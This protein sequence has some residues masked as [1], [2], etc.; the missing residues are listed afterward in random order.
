METT[1]NP[2]RHRALQRYEDRTPT[3]RALHEKACR[4]VPGGVS[5]NTLAFEPYPFA[6]AEAAGAHLTDVDGNT[7]LDLVNNFTSLP[8]GH[9]HVPTLEAATAELRRSSAVG[10]AHVLEAEY[11]AELRRRIP[12]METLHFT[13]TGSE[14]VGLAVRVARAHTGRVRVLKFEGGFHG[15]HNEVTQ[16]IATR[17]PLAPGTAVPARPASAG[18]E[19]T[20]TVTGVYND[21]ASVHTA[22]ARWGDEIAVV[23]LEPF[24]GNAGLI[25]AEQPFV[26]AIF[27]AARAAGALVLVDEIQALRARVGGAHMTWDHTPDLVTVGKIMGGG[28]PL[29]AFGGRAA[30]MATLTGADR[31][32]QTGTFTATPPSLAAGRAAMDLFGADV[33]DELDRRTGRLRAG[34]RSALADAGLPG[35]VSGL[36]SMFNLAMSAEPVTSYRALRSADV[37]LLADIRLELLNRGFLIMPR[38]TGCLST[39]VTDDDV[40]RFL[41]AVG[42]SIRVVVATSPHSQE[43]SC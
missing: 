36:G 2:A 37:E 42:E 25:T 35:Y 13:T 19:P 12:A 21:P 6:T 18:L 29:A 7:Y 15:S 31:V 27:T 14:A 43:A 33:Y 41:S 40:D 11:A 28:F 20:T 10:T 32:I 22:F 30:A 1:L 4:I 16:D 3:S 38:G 26:D 8:H 23:V 39:A 34:L 9:G 17:A 24:L 5:R